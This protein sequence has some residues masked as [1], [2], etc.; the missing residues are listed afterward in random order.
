VD[1]RIISAL[2]AAARVV[3]FTGAA[4]AASDPGGNRPTTSLLPRNSAPWY[5]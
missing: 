5:W 2:R 1:G 4:R 3:V